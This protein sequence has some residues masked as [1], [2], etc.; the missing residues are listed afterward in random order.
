MR[1]S[2]LW[3]EAPKGYK[4]RDTE[5]PLPIPFGEGGPRYLQTPDVTP[6]TTASPVTKPHPLLNSTTDYTHSL[7]CLSILEKGAYG[8]YLSK[9]VLLISKG[10]PRQVGKGVERRT[11]LRTRT[12]MTSSLYHKRCYH[13][14]SSPYSTLQIVKDNKNSVIDAARCTWVRTTFC[15]EEIQPLTYL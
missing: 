10:S 6:T 15:L 8:T 11:R 7:F 9:N 3:E 12:S 1:T 13:V 14:P 4:K 2:V 5:T